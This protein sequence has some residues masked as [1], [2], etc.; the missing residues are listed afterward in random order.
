MKSFSSRVNQWLLG[1]SVAALSQVA[2]AQPGNAR[3]S[4]ESFGE[5]YASALLA[6]PSQTRVFVYRTPQASSQLPVNIYLNGQ[7]HASLLKGG[8]TEFCTDPGSVN[9]KAAL[10]DASRLHL[11]KQDGGQRMTMQTGQT[12][13]LRS[14]RVVSPT[15]P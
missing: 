5:A 10:D 8:F 7:Y 4:I 1:L 3:V 12:L 11:S 14:T 15:S 9:V 2:M 6:P 13:F